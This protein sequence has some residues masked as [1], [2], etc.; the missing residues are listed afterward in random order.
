MF[1]LENPQE[2][3]AKSGNQCQHQQTTPPK[4]VHSDSAGCSKSNTEPHKFSQYDHSFG[5]RALPN[6]AAP[7]L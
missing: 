6:Q 4:Q 3:H 2:D 5:K 1:L 7:S